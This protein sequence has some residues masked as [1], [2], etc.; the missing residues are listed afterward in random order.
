M[1]YLGIAERLKESG[2]TNVANIE[3]LLE[4]YLFHTSNTYSHFSNMT[5]FEVRLSYIVKAG[6]TQAIDR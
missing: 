6:G 5:I 2:K 1:A 4:P 3:D